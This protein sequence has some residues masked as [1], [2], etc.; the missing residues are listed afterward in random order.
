MFQLCGFAGSAP[1]LSGSGLKNLPCDPDSIR[2]RKL[3][4]PVRSAAVSESLSWPVQRGLLPASYKKASK[5]VAVLEIAGQK[6]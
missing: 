6:P 5:P 2:A 3:S 4:N 1:A